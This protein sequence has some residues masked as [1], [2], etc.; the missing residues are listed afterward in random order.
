VAATDD[1]FPGA[2]P[3][4]EPA[5]Q[6]REDAAA[7]LVEPA[8]QR[9]IAVAADVLGR[10]SSEDV[11]PALRPLAKFAPVKRIR[12]G[13]TVLAGA[14]DADSSFRE[15]VSRVVADGS[16]QLADAVR[17]GASTAASDPIDTAVVAYLLRPDGWQQ[18]LAAANARWLAERDQSGRVVQ[19][20]Q[21]RQL[22]D[23]V[24][25][26]KAQARVDASQTK[27]DLAAAAK[28]VSAELAAVRKQVRLQ[29]AEIQSARRERDDAVSAAAEAV[30]DAANATA[31]RDT[32]GRRAK[33]RIAELERALESARRA[34]RTERDLD[35]ARLWLLLDTVAEA[36][37]GIRRELS[38]PAPTLRPADMIADAQG[39]AKPAPRHADDPV[40]LDR[41]LALPNAHLIVDG[42]NVTKSGYGELPLADQRRRLVG[43]LAGIANRTGAEITVAFDGAERPPIMPAAPRG[44]R[45]LFSA[46]DEIADDLIRQLVAAEPTGRTVIVVSTDQQVA[47]D[48]RRAG[49]WS[50]SSRVLLDRLDQ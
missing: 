38:L 16:P 34:G 13:A 1:R 48:I 27:A 42:Y 5:A 20:A 31:A 43:A 32:E 21:L 36:A 33:A 46:A 37:A 26:L 18:T 9:L 41:L 12:L 50:V 47:V 6:A 14:L 44:V 24:A 17:T 40:A 10:L 11:P 4:D 29:S 25:A 19:D 22:R 45:V 2:D 8:R 7:V 39:E 15:H 30:R 3:V 23:E 35:D 28:D 49:A